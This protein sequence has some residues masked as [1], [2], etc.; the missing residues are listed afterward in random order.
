MAYYIKSVNI[1]WHNKGIWDKRFVASL[2]FIRI[3]NV[4]I[5]NFLII[6]PE[7]V[8]VLLVLCPHF[9]IRH[10]CFVR[11]R[12]RITRSREPYGNPFGSLKISLDG[13]RRQTHLRDLL[14]DEKSSEV[15]STIA[16]PWTTRERTGERT[17]LSGNNRYLRGFKFNA[18][19]RLREIS[20]RVC[21][22]FSIFDS[23]RRSR[24][25]RAHSSPRTTTRA[26][27]HELV[28]L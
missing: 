5:N 20:R 18:R 11:L 17:V 9:S 16:L 8:I 14:F 3:L 23:H 7:C 25:T 21:R 4:N 10:C 24:L 27:S 2:I 12:F 28:P 6:G 13:E 26:R 19:V 1:F 15:T 22:N